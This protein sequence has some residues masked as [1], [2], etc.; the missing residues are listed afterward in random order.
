MIVSEIVN[1][2]WLLNE[3]VYDSAK[4]SEAEDPG[5]TLWKNTIKLSADRVLTIAV[6]V[7]VQVCNC[8]TPLVKLLIMATI[9]S[10]PFARLE[11]RHHR[12]N[13]IEQ[14]ALVKPCRSRVRSR[15]TFHLMVWLI[16][17]VVSIKIFV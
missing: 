2:L 9:C 10:P 16:A 1:L 4:P 15:I 7:I 11:K 12:S 6:W 8:K 13:R 17:I 14:A 5:F 3:I